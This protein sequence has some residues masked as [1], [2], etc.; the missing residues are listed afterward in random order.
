MQGRA[1]VATSAAERD[2]VFTGMHPFEQRGDPERK[3]VAVV[4]DLDKIAGR[5]AGGTMFSMES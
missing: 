1:H 2:Q 5:M 3:G 4:I